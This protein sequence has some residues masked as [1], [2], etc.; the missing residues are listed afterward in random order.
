MTDINI[1]LAEE[2][3][4]VATDLAVEL[5]AS[6]LVLSAINSSVAGVLKSIEAEDVDFAVLNV[7]L[8]DGVVYPAARQ[9]KTLNIPFAFLT[10]FDTSEIDSEFR[11]VPCLS[12]P[13]A[14]RTIAE[15]VAGLAKTP[16]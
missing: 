11:D 16:V 2:D 13:Q 4:V 9:L 8:R 10:S 6:G 14:P 7:G 5:E 12:K 15:F 1:L 3:V